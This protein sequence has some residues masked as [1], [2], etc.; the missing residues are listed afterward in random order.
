M[1]IKTDINVIKILPRYRVPEVNKKAI[2]KKNANNKK[3]TTEQYREELKEKDMDVEVLEEY[4]NART[5]ILHRFL[6]CGHI[7]KVSPDSILRGSKCLQCNNKKLSQDRIKTQKQF[8]DELFIANNS[9]KIIGKY[10]GANKPIEIKCLIC[11]YMWY[12]IASS[13]IKKSY[14]N[15][16][17]RCAGLIVTSFDFYEKFNKYGNKNIVLT[18]EYVNSHTK[19]DGYCKICGYVIHMFPYQLTSGVGC[20]MCISK[21]N[22]LKLKKTQEQFIL[23]VKNKNPNIEIIGKYMGAQEPVECRCLLCSHIWNP[24]AN[25]IL[26][27]KNYGCPQCNISHGEINISNYLKE[28]NIKYTPQYRLSSLRG[29]GNKPLSYDFYLPNKKILIEFQGEQHERPI[30]HFGGKKQFIIQQ[31]HDIRKRKYAKSHGIRL[32]TIWYNQ[33]NDIEEI[34]DNYLNNL[35]LESVETTGVA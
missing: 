7:N 31:I 12:P 19:I 8:E 4:I 18:S 21:I 2:G 11:G 28:N 27:N 32:I 24:I 29:V 30:N 34:L 1:D 26:S 9:L 20:K 35:K 22:G 6:N 25:N 10:V 3:K 16:C 15:G 13:L 5:P 14:K 33:I 17:P 23:E